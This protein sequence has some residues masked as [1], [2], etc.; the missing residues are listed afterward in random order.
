MSLIKADVPANLEAGIREILSEH[1]LK[2]QIA[3]IR[4]LTRANIL[5]FTDKGK[6]RSSILTVIQQDLFSLESQLDSLL[7]SYRD[8]TFRSVFPPLSGKILSEIIEEIDSGTTNGKEFQKAL[9][10]HAIAHMIELNKEIN[11]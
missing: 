7:N 8:L 3:R 9:L 10:E 11:D 1:N 6:Y 5:A 2:E 4:N